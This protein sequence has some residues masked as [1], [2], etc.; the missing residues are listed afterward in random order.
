M[1][2]LFEIHIEDFSGFIE[3]AIIISSFLNT[4][5]NLLVEKKENKEHK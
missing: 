1:S 4:Q 5:K 3:L 2:L